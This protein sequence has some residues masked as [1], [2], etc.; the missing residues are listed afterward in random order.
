MFKRSLA[1]LAAVAIASGAVVAPANAMTAKV[2][3]GGSC[4][5]NLTDEEV[6][7][8]RSH[9]TPKFTQEEA[10]SV[11][12]N[13]VEK[14]LSDLDAEIEKAQKELAKSELE[15]EEK[16]RLTRELKESEKKHKV[17]E[18][19]RDALTACIAGQDYP[20]GN[21]GD[22][23]NPDGTQNPGGTEKPKGPGK[24]GGTDQSGGT[25][26]PKAPS[27]PGV[28][29]APP[30]NDG[31]GIGVIFAGAIA[32]ILGILAAAL[33]IIKPMLPPQLRALLP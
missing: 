20:S 14:Q 23:K 13:T 24:P 6:K 12:A 2:N 10:A 28:T 22:S 18:N 9:Q 26:K 27:N 21:P 4:T 17:Y 29:P 19:Y 32:A 8:T 3:N 25:E 31:A 16:E 7:L 30:S 1:S 5:F 11:K 33:P 15:E